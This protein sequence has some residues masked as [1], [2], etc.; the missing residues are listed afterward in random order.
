[1][2][3]EN[4]K[5]NVRSVTDFILN[6]PASSACRMEKLRNSFFLSKK[7][8]KKSSLFSSDV[9]HNVVYGFFFFFFFFYFSIFFLL[10]RRKLRKW[11]EKLNNKK[12]KLFIDETV[13][14]LYINVHHDC[15]WWYVVFIFQTTYSTSTTG[16]KENIDKYKKSCAFEK[17]KIPLPREFKEKFGLFLN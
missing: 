2:K 5:C 16:V 10:F 9:R 12:K 13:K 3:I 11:K 15:R 6:W 14:V 1:M 7:K 17:W 8:K 4:W